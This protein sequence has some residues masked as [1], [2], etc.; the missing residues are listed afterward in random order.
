MYTYTMPEKLCEC[1]CGQKTNIITMTRKS[2]GAIKGEYRRFV[3][4]HAARVSHAER[5]NKILE[6]GEKFC[7][8]CRET[9]SLEDF[10]KSPQHASGYYSYCKPCKA[11]KMREAN[12]RYREANPEKNRQNN[13]R[14]FLKKKY[15]ISLED[16]EELLQS[17]GGKCAICGVEPDPLALAVDHCHESLEIRGLLCASC[18]WGVGHFRDDIELL[19]AAAFYLESEGTGKFT[20]R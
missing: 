7:P 5:L 16:Y 11:R 10:P 15:G 18:N 1:G 20:P 6:S 14:A 13:K 3:V 2:T 12:S 4:G 8:S 19:Y 17:Q 9:K